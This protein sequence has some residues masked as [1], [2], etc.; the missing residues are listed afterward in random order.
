M[1]IP[2]VNPKSVMLVIAVVIAI[3]VA[4]YYWT[5]SSNASAMLGPNMMAASTPTGTRRA[6]SM[7]DAPP[8]AR[9]SLPQGYETGFDLDFT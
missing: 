8:T 9:E 4:V 1:K 6:M 3:N 5:R 7:G 2:K